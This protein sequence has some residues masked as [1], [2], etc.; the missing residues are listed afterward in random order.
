[1]SVSSIVR[2]IDRHRRRMRLDEVQDLQRRR[3]VV[4]A[5]DDRA[6]ARQA[7]GHQAL[8][9]RRV[10][11]HDALAGGRGLAHA[12][13]VEVERDVGDL[14][15][16]E[17]ARQVLAAAAEAADDDVRLGVDRALRAIV[18]IATDCSSQSLADRRITMRLLYM[19]MSGVASIDST[20]LASTGL[21]Q[22]RAAAA[23][24]RLARLEQ[25]EAELAGLREVEAGAQ[26]DAGRRAEGARQHRDEGELEEHRQQRQHEHERPVSPARRRGR[27]SCRR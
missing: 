24:A 13:G 15:G 17:Q 10:A 20:M 14:L 18:V 9:A 4:V 3:R 11:E 16:L 5:D 25:H 7:R 26:R 6:G 2:T 12:V 8:Q 22:R 23:A 1:M 27:A 19:K 21:L